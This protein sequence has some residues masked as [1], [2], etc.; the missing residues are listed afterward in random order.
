MDLKHIDW[1]LVAVWVQ[2]VANTV[3]LFM[4]YLQMK[5][6]QQQMTQSDAQERFSRSWEFV[7]LYRDELREFEQRL[8]IYR[9][10]FDPLT[11]DTKSD[12]FNA[13]LSYFYKPRWHLFLLLNHLIRHQEVDERILFDYLGEEFNR[14]V[15]IGVINYGLNFKTDMCNQMD[16]LVT[17]WGAQIKASR[18]LYSTDFPACELPTNSTPVGT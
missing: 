3:V 9:D 5:Q 7:K 8:D 11:A 13:Y 2:T 6:V 14:F 16:I 18:L 15:E 1:N 12:A 4:I 17:S 10:G